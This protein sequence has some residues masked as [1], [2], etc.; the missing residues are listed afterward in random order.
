MIRLDGAFVIHFSMVNLL[1][2]FTYSI[3]NIFSIKSREQAL[4]KNNLAVYNTKIEK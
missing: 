4:L 3:L 1:Q 2:K